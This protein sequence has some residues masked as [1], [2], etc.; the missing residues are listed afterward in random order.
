[1][2]LSVRRVNDYASI[3]EFA[4]EK[5]MEDT[6]ANLHCIEN[7]EEKAT[8]LKKAVRAGRWDDPLFE[9]TNA[10]FIGIQR[11]DFFE[12][13]FIALYG[14]RRK[15]ISYQDFFT[16]QCYYGLRTQFAKVEIHFHRIF[17]KNRAINKN[18]QKLLTECLCTHLKKCD[19]NLN[20][21]KDQFQRFLFLLQQHRYPHELTLFS[22]KEQPL[23]K[24][25]KTETIW[26]QFR[27]EYDISVF[28]NNDRQFIPALITYQIF[29][30]ILYP[31][32]YDIQLQA[33]I[34]LTPPA[35]Q[36][37]R[38]EGLFDVLMPWATCYP[39]TIDDFP[40][41][42]LEGT[43]HD[44][45]GHALIVLELPP[46]WRQQVFQFTRE[47]REFETDYQGNLTNEATRHIL[48]DNLLDLNFTHVSRFDWNQPITSQSL[49]AL[50]G[51]LVRELFK[52]RRLFNITPAH[53]EALQ[54]HIH[55]LYGK[56]I[57]N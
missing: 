22:V 46:K 3:I 44:L 25:L 47:L 55:L 43:Y 14:L 34:G 10:S 21:S 12:F 24:M 49:R 30:K 33:R 38:Q 53:R 19:K 57:Q 41:P 26:D 16:I 27:Y 45:F 42:G 54:H 1:M 6:E 40:A 28:S 23:S 18:T 7:K 29:I 51:P 35:R 31:H 37:E 9:R 17:K 48:S 56:I 50:F 39:E 5:V 2:P 8:A 20:F 15:A 32:S 13:P 11:G 4:S 36:F 52:D